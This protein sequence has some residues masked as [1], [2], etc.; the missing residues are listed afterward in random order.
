MLI[1]LSSGTWWFTWA[2]ILHPFQVHQTSL[3]DN[4]F[5][6]NSISINCNV[7]TTRHR[8]YKV[9]ETPIDR[10]PMTTRNQLAKQK[11]KSSFFFKIRRKT[12]PEISFGIGQNS[13]ESPAD[14]NHI[15]LFNDVYLRSK[16]FHFCKYTSKLLVSLKSQPNPNT[17]ERARPTKTRASNDRYLINLLS[18]LSIWKWWI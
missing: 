1:K 7:Q 6:L 2:Y 16:M 14:T 9:T 17:R 18:I 12:K 10:R 11:P 5:N 4:H 8:Q 13:R 15:L 3:W